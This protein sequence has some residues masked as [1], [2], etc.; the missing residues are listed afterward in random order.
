MTKSG[1][2]R[3]SWW[4]VAVGVTAVALAAATATNFE[5][6]PAATIGAWLCLAVLLGGYVLFGWRSF[7]TADPSTN[8][9]AADAADQ[10]TRPAAVIFPLLAIVC[11]SVGVGFDANLAILDRKSTRTN[12]RHLGP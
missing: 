12:S 6:D 9:E 1:V 11:T 3:F 2:W 10:R 7:I 8:T 5:A 4:H